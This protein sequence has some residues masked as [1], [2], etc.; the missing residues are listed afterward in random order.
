MKKTFLTAL[1]ITLLA[2]APAAAQTMGSGMQPGMME[3]KQDA[4]Q[5]DEARRRMMPSGTVADMMAGPGRNMMG[6]GYGMMPM[7]MGGGSPM[8]GSGYGM[9]PMMMGGGSPMMGSGYGMMPMMMGGGSPM[10]GSGYGMMPMMMGGGCSMAPAMGGHG[11]MTGPAMMHYLG[12]ENLEKYENIVKETRETRK[13]LHDLIFEY[14]EAKWNPDT[15]LGQLRKMAEE[16][17][18]LQDEVREKA[19]W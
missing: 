8:M 10:M 15:T 11:M 4:A 13:K 12:R 19:G 6:S 16:I 5:T 3:E 18:R 7:M 17:N 1:A 14:G 9:M 2:S